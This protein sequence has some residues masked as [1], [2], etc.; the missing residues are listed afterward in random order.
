MPDRV[1]LIAPAKVNLYLAVGERGPDGYHPLTTVFQALDERLS[2]SVEVRAAPTFSLSMSPDLGIPASDNLA[3]RGALLLAEE[4]GAATGVSIA[5]DKRIPAG[6]GLGGASSDAAAVLLGASVLWGVDPASDAVLR[7][8]RSLGADVPFFLHGGTGLYSGRGDVLVKSLPTPRLDIV[9][10]TA[11]EP[12]ATGAAYALFDRLPHDPAPEPEAILKAVGCADA[13]AIAAALH[14]DL[15]PAARTLAPGVH[16]VEGWL[17][18]QDGVLGAAVT[19]SGSCVYGV[20]ASGEA[21][22]RTAASALGAGW[23][24]Q[25]CSTSAEGARVVSTA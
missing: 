10:V 20:C 19:G 1:T 3:L 14:N 6:G 8:A 4:V 18:A 17:R 24:A 7:C 15:A 5:V 16:A 13:A 11:G 9:V 25:A 22:A 12:V 23:W 2:D 21:A